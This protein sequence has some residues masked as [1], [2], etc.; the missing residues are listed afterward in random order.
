MSTLNDL[1][2]RRQAEAASAAASSSSGSSTVV[3]TPVAAKVVK[4]RK[5]TEQVSHFSTLISSF[6][7]QKPSTEQ[8]SEVGKE[9]KSDDESALLTPQQRNVAAKI[10]EMS[11]H[12][13]R[14]RDEALKYH[15]KQEQQ[16]QRIGQGKEFYMITF[17]PDTQGAEAIEFLTRFGFVCLR[18]AVSLQKLQRL[19]ARINAWLESIQTGLQPGDWSTFINANMPDN[20]TSGVLDGVAPPEL[21]KTKRKADA[22]ES[23]ML[24][25]S[26]DVGNNFESVVASS[27]DPAS[28]IGLCCGSTP[29]N[30]ILNR[31][32]LVDV[33]AVAENND[34]LTEQF[35]ATLPV[36]AVAREA[37]AVP[38]GVASSSRNGAVPYEDEL[39]CESRVVSEFRF[40]VD[41]LTHSQEA[42]DVRT[43][44]RIYRFFRRLLASG[45][46]L[47][48]S[49]DRFLYQR[50]LLARAKSS[51]EDWKNNYEQRPTWEQNPYWQGDPLCMT[52][53]QQ[54]RESKQQEKKQEQ[55]KNDDGARM[56]TQVCKRPRKV[57]KKG[58]AREEEESEE[59]GDI[60]PCTAL[61]TGYQ[62]LLA[63]E[64]MT[65]DG[66]AVSLVPAFHTVY[67]DY[68]AAHAAEWR[69]VVDNVVRAQ[70]T[71]KMAQS[72]VVENGIQIAMRA[73]TMLVYDKRLPRWGSVNRRENT[74]AIGMFISM[75]PRQPDFDAAYRRVRALSVRYGIRCTALRHLTGHSATPARW[76][77]AVPASIYNNYSMPKFTEL[78]LCLL[79]V[80]RYS[81]EVVYAAQAQA[82][83]PSALS[84]A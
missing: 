41:T 69:N 13:T 81:D 44:A 9:R 55:K 59:E 4:K 19:R 78:G 68:A 67:Q 73:G 61:F 32:N 83:A 74:P 56:M 18:D 31:E 38:V 49:I 62:G 51:T 80:R 23:I 25:A 37:P 50:P 16:Q 28:T 3:A 20:F 64:D 79:G 24:A 76:K 17:D 6:V 34:A 77:R 48:V 63:L 58:D 21:R 70:K 14:E 40:R 75:W 36:Y 10:K 2:F 65:V 54:K 52:T 71:D 39:L 15:Q 53:V 57:C 35:R 84:N 7:R 26:S 12:L 82:Q 33:H 43:D 11:A 47:L 22:Y 45:D 5:K 46:D 30:S 8:S 42:W 60:E 29:P 1:F 72:L 66:G 27:S